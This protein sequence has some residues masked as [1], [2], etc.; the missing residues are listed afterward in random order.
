MEWIKLIDRLP[1]KEE[2]QLNNKHFL[3]LDGKN[4]DVG[5]YIEQYDHKWWNTYE[6]SL[7]PTH[8]QPLP[9][10]PK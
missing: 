10:A 5:V 9:K 7:H 4:V 3:V 2:Q 1:N 8:W 6:D